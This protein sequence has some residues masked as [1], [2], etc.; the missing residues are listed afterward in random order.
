MLQIIYTTVLTVLTLENRGIILLL[1]QHTDLYCSDGCRLI[2]MMSKFADK[3]VSPE[4]KK[5][6]TVNQMF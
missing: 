3:L 5:L 2:L 6:P 4:E 1:I